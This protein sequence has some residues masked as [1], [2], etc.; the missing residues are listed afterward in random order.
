MFPVYLDVDGRTVYALDGRGLRIEVGTVVEGVA[1]GCVVVSRAR[2]PDA[3]VGT[4]RQVPC[5]ESVADAESLLGRG[6]E[7]IDAPGGVA[8]LLSADAA[9]PTLRCVAVADSTPQPDATPPLAWGGE[10]DGW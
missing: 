2:L 1:G 4:V 7:V 3:I 9:S 6:A 5:V 10:D 8:D